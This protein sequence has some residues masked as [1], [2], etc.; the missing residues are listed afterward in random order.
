MSRCTRLAAQRQLKREHAHLQ[1]L[2]QHSCHSLHSWRVVGHAYALSQHS[3][4]Q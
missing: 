4:Q 1:W 2:E 3:V